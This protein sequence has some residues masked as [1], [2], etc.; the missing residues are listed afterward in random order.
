M[1]ELASRESLAE[2]DEVA[3]QA[4]QLEHAWALWGC[5]AGS[6]LTTLHTGRVARERLQGRYLGGHS[7]VF[8]ETK[9]LQAGLIA[10]VEHWYGLVA[11]AFYPD[12]IPL[13]DFKGKAEEAADVEVGRIEQR[14]IASTHWGLGEYE[15]ARS[16]AYAAVR[17][18]PDT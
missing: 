5:D 1:R 8:P 3:T 6:L 16:V 7:A 18:R 14:A 13:A 2:S 12:A 11:E 10:E 15:A 4:D 17:G 9:G